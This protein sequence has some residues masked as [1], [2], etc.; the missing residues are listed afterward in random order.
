MTP[1]NPLPPRNQPSAQ[2]LQTLFTDGRYLESPRWHGERLWFVDSLARTVCSL[3]SANDVVV[4]CR[5]D[6]IPSGLGFLPDGELL[7][8]LM[9]GKQIVKY[10]QG[11]VEHYADLTNVAAG[12]LDDMIVDSRGY[13]YVGDLGFDLRSGQFKRNGGGLIR[14]AAD[15][16]ATRVAESLDF[17]NGIAFAQDEKTLVVAESSGD[18]LSRFIIS[19]GGLHFDQ[20]FGKFGEPDGI[21]LDREG[22]VWVSLFKEDSFVRVDA[23]GTILERIAVPGR[24]AVAS[25]LGGADRQTL[26]CITA[27]TTHQQLMRGESRAQ[28]G[29]VQV[30]V[31][32]AGI[33]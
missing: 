22:A 16:S 31:P 10:S 27:E 21:C 2:G 13:A 18:C 25:V 26:F 7:I 8:V 11:Q 9:F 33:P 17:P 15:G 20:Q 1:A 12:T 30:A 4:H 6:D 5:L 24:R 23:T 29:A 28:I 32:G 3:G 19:P 14:V